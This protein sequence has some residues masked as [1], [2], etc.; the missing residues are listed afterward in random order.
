MRD[1]AVVRKHDPK[2]FPVFKDEAVT[3]HND[4]VKVVK[5]TVV[6]RDDRM[7]QTCARLIVGRS[8]IRLAGTS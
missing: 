3:T 8:S 5:E 4:F 7:F 1:Q 6:Q 2:N